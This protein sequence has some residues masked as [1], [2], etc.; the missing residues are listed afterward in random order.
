VTVSGLNGFNSA[1]TLGCSGQPVN[2]N[3][4]FS[5]TSLSPASGGTATAMMTIATNSSPYMHGQVVF[6]NPGERI[7][8]LL[9]P[10]PFLALLAVLLFGGARI[11]RLAGR[12]WVHGLTGTVAILIATACVLA[13]SG[14]GYN[15]SAAGNGTQRGT[16]TVMIIGTSGQLS[17]STAVTR[18]V[19]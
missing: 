10:I 6:G 18:T 4:S 7:Y 14:C 19:Q 12:R 1:I 16:D 11:D 3:C 5:T 8:T 13:A 9:L 17:H 15:S 2:S